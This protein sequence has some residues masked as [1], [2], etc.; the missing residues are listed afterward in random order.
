M[1][2]LNNLQDSI[3]KNEPISS[4]IQEVLNELNFKTHEGTQFY[5]SDDFRSTMY[6]RA[7]AM[8]RDYAKRNGN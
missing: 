7:M 5:Y 2:I 3:N 1:N 8:I 6:T 4:I